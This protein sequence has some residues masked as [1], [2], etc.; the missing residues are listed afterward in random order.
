MR[1]NFPNICKTY[2]RTVNRLTISKDRTKTG[3]AKEE[4]EGGCVHDA[5]PDLTDLDKHVA[6]YV[7]ESHC[8]NKNNFYEVFVHNLL[9]A[10]DNRADL[11]LG[12]MQ[13]TLL[14]IDKKTVQF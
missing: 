5:D 11:I 1:N 2:N 9:L 3:E 8:Q 10:L 14:S 6:D 12:P 4:E 7:S 13:I